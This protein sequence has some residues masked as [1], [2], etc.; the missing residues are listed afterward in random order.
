MVRSTEQELPSFSGSGTT[1]LLTANS[2][3]R[4]CV[5]WLEESFSTILTSWRLYAALKATHLVVS[6]AEPVLFGRSW[7]ST[8]DKTE[9]ILNDTVFS[10]FV[11]T[12]IK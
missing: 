9:E 2:C 1:T 10:S 6:V 11:L 4:G 3:E 8:L 12:L 7:S 5:L